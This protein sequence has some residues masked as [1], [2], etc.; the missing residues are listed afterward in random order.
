MISA[1][2]KDVNLVVKVKSDKEKEYLKEC[3]ISKMINSKKEVA[4]IIVDA[5]LQC[6]LK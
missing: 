1:Y 2:T 4:N 3:N 6:Q 5:T